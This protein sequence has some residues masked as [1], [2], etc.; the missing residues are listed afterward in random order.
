MP[1][2]SHA[3]GVLGR[4]ASK[5]GPQHWEEMNHLLHYISNIRTCGIKYTNTSSGEII[6]KTSNWNKYSSGFFVAYTDSD[7]AGCPD[8]CRSTSGNII[9]WMG[10]AV[11]WNSGLQ[12]C[13]TLS[14]AEAEMVALCK[15]AQEVIW[16]RRLLQELRGSEAEPSKIFC[17]N[18]ATLR[19]CQNRVHHARTKHIALR[20]MFITEHTDSGELEPTH[21]PTNDNLADCFTKPVKRTI[22]ESHFREITGMDLV[23]SN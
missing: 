1:T 9:T 18:Q 21:I 7:F 22:L 12:A 8:T 6:C 17:D 3:V 10:A 2:I 13:V 5:S 14:T 15:A 16:L 4:F 19:L 11:C 20:Q 23:Y